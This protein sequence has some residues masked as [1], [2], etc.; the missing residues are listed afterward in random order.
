MGKKIKNIKK[1]IFYIKREQKKT[2]KM[3]MWGEDE[4]KSHGY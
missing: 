4:K 3:F 1:K 2:L